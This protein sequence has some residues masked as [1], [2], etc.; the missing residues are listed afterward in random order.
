MLRTASSSSSG[1]GSSGLSANRLLPADLLGVDLLERRALLIACDLALRGVRGR[2]CQ[3]R[4]RA[5][6]LGH[7]LHPLDQ[8]LEPLALVDELAGFEIDE[9]ADHPPA[10]RAPEVL[11]DEPV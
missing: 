2:D 7:G 9:L 11:F 8:L 6:L 10:D 1:V 3:E 5:D 4:S